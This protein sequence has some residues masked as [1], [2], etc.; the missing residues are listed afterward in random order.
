MSLD[1]DAGELT[2]TALEFVRR[3]DGIALQYLLRGAESRARSLIDRGDVNPGLGDVLDKLAGLAAVF[4]DYEQE[5]WFDRVVLVLKHIYSMPLREGDALRFGYD[6]HPAGRGRAARVADDYSEGVSAVEGLAVRRHAW[7]AVRTLSLQQPARL[8]D[9]ETNWLRHALTMASRAQHLQERRGDGSQVNVSLLSL[10]R[11]DIDRL[12]CLR[13][14]GLEPG[15]DE[16]LTSLARFD[17][18]SNVAAIDGAGHA[19]RRVFSNFARFRQSRIQPVVEQLL[20]DGGM[21]CGAAHQGRRRPCR[22]TRGRIAHQEGM[23][24]DGFEGLDHTPVAEFLTEHL[25]G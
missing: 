15:D 2:V 25:R 22:C 8:G 14:T 24:F 5:D 11:T 18:L 16:I 6:R 13:P 4:L 1:L 17:I 12:A 20:T 21:P 9:Y 10:A 19:Q 3:G 23:R 7:K